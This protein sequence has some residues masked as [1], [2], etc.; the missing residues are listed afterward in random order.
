MALLEGD[1]ANFETLMRA[2][3]SGHLAL[4][5]SKRTSDG[6]YV[7]LLA[8]VHQE[9]PGGDFV[10]TPFAEMARGNPY[11]LYEDPSDPKFGRVGPKD[12]N[13]RGRR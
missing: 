10:I 5:E 9:S 7:A 12:W 6:S 8:A 3:R 1:R 2:V 13:P 11:E 4:V